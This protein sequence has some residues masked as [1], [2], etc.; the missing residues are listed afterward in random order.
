MTQGVKT[1]ALDIV[2]SKIGASVGRGP[3]VYHSGNGSTHALQAGRTYGGRRPTVQSHGQDL[4]QHNTDLVVQ[5]SWE[6]GKR[7]C[8]LHGTIQPLSD[9]RGGSPGRRREMRSE[10]SEVGAHRYGLVQALDNQP[11]Q[12]GS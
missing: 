10:I 2:D 8:T 7:L 11:T 6:R 12:H 1:L 5:R 9:G 3:P 4:A